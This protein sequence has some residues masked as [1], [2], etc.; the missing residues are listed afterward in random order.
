MVMGSNKTKLKEIT[1]F[2]LIWSKTWQTIPTIKFSMVNISYTKI[3]ENKGNLVM[4]SNAVVFHFIK[5][6]NM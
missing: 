2:C 6:H 4:E 5:L 3:E 1:N